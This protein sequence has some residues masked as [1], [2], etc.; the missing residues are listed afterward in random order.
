MKQQKNSPIKLD[1][2]NNISLWQLLPAGD[3]LALKKLRAIVNCVLHGQAYR[4]TNK[5]LSLL[6]SG[7]TGKKTHSYA[8]L[9]ALGIEQISHITANLL[10]T[11]R[12]VVDFFCGS[13]PDSGFL[14]SNLNFLPASM[15][16]KVYQILEEGQH[17]SVDPYKVEVVATPVYGII[18]CTAKNEKLVPQVLRNTFDYHC[19]LRNYTPQQK[20]LICLQRLKYTNIGIEDERVLQTLFLNSTSDLNDLMKLLKLSIVVMMAEGR[21]VLT[22]SD[23]RKGKELW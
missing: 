8:F 6:I 11:P 20:E 21:N 10:Q 3:G 14:I 19:E 12:D 17:K 22:S 7:E 13:T 1:E 2:Y 23:V 4:E 9:K 16:K 18:V 5:P 15:Q